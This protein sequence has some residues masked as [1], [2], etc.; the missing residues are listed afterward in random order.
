MKVTVVLIIIGEI[1]RVQ[2]SFAKGFKETG[3]RK[4]PDLTFA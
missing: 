1:G 2:N 4:Q 3:I